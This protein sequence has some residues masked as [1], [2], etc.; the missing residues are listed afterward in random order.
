MSGFVGDLSPKQETALQKFKENIADVVEPHHDDSFL[1]R[2]LRARH[3]DVA[4]AEKMIRSSLDYKKK[5]RLDELYETWQDS[6]VMEKYFVG[7]LCGHDKNGCPIW[8]DPFGNIDPKGIIYSCKSSDIIKS[9]LVLSEKVHKICKEQ[10]KKLGKRV[11][12]CVVIFDLENVTLNHI[13]KPFID[14]YGQVLAL[15]EANYPEALEKCFITRAPRLFS[16]GYN[17]VK[18]FLSEDTKKKVFILGNDFQD[19]LL[20]HI[21]ADQLPQHFGGTLKDPDGDPRYTTKVC[22]GGKVP[23]SYYL[24]DKELNTESMVSTT[25]K[26]GAVL[27]LEYS[28]EEPGSHIRYEFS[29]EGADIAFGIFKKNGNKEMVEVL[30]VSRCKSNIVLE[31]GFFR[32][33]EPGSYVVRFDNSFSWIKSKKIKYLVEVLPPDKEIEDQID[34]ETEITGVCNGISTQL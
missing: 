17:M 13:W 24:K 21:D 1:L 22:Y 11:E 26:S 33:D 19:V 3:W 8:I 29:S 34:N 9:K 10:S 6:E 27:D 2:W 28:V 15:F 30:P 25:V 18:P 5:M 32:V 31:D 23:E 16:V 14:L 20:Q 7:G 4:K 12:T